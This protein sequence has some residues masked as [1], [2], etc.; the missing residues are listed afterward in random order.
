MHRSSPAEKRHAQPAALG[1]RHLCGSPP[2]RECLFTLQR[3]RPDRSPPGQDPTELARLYPPR[4]SHHKHPPREI[5]S[6]SL[7]RR[8]GTVP[9]DGSGM[10]TL[11]E[12]SIVLLLAIGLLIGVVAVLRPFTTAILFGTTL[13]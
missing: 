6:H 7:V 11:I 5:Q 3:L 8:S 12:R 4:R 10:V 1:H 13:A 9:L 2:R